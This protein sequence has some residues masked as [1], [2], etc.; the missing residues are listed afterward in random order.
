MRLSVIVLTPFALPVQAAQFVILCPASACLAVRM[1]PLCTSEV[2]RGINKAPCPEA[3]CFGEYSVIA[4]SAM[5]SIAA[6]ASRT[7]M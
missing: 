7:A 3:R 6:L 1:V 2:L 4:Q 5:P